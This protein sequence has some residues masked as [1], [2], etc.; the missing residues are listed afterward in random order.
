[1][2]VSQQEMLVKTLDEGPDGEREESAEVRWRWEGL[3]NHF[4]ILLKEYEITG[5]AFL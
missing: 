4:C 3:Y 2:V 5:T 1:M